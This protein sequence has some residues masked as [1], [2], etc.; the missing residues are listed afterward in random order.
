MNASSRWLA[1][2][3]LALSL[4]G[5]ASERPASNNTAPA[6]AQSSAP[7]PAAPAAA[8]AQTKKGPRFGALAYDAASGAWGAAYDQTSRPAADRRALEECRPFGRKCAVV[9]R[10]ANECSA[11]ARGAGAAKGAGKGPSR[12][13]AERAALSACSRRGKECSVRIWACTAR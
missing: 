3:I 13:Q 2:A 9:A 8:A 10:F 5:C 1:A 11:Y 7:P 6:P 4:C 12:E